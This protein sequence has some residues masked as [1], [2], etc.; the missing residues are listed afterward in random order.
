VD[1]I[2]SMKLLSE[3]FAGQGNG[4]RMLWEQTRPLE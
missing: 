4:L 2:A 1:R 3:R